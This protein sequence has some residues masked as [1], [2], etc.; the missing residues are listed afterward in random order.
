ML[1]AAGGRDWRC[2]PSQSEQLYVAARKQG[3][4]A[5]L[6][7]YEDEHHNI[8]EPE[9]AIHRTEEVLAWYERFDPAVDTDADD[10]HDRR[11]GGETD[12]T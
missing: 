12:E 1:I 6:V 2:P 10:P 9:R 4:P 5:R 3:V 7:V 11:E 8:G